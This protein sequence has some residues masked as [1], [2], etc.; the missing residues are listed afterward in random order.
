LQEGTEKSIGFVLNS[1]HLI[2]E[3]NGFTMDP[4]NKLVLLDV[5]SLFTNVPIDRALESIDSR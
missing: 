3:L 1:Y 5:I 2:N 4:I